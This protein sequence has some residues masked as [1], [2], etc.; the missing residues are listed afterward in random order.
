M[1]GGE[2][3]EKAQF[4]REIVV[5]KWGELGINRNLDW[6]SKGLRRLGTQFIETLL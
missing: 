5:V 2:S 1:G 6:K 3:P 4:G